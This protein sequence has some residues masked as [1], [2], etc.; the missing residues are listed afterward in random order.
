MLERLHFS[1]TAVSLTMSECS[2]NW[3]ALSMLM[4]SEFSTNWCAVSVFCSSVS[5]DCV[6]QLTP[7]R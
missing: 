5:V 3:C 1:P 6:Y 7:A 4:M 2:S